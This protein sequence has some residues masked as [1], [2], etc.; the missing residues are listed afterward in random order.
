MTLFQN[1]IRQVHLTVKNQQALS[2]PD[3]AI[4]VYLSR[5]RR[6]RLNTDL[7]GPEA[8]T[9]GVFPVLTAFFQNT[10][11]RHLTYYLTK[12]CRGLLQT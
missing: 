3:P 6:V 1:F 7:W 9:P 10:T 11:E 2:H 8:S 12:H 5:A 4:S